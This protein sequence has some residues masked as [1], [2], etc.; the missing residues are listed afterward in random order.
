MPFHRSFLIIALAVLQ[1]QVTPA[2]ASYRLT[3]WPAAA[4]QPDFQ[5]IDM[6]GHRRSLSDYAGGVSIVFFGYT[7]CPDVC[8]TELLELSQILR[9]LGP[10]ASHVQVLFVTLDP[11]RDTILAQAAP[12]P[13]V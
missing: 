9:T 13:S 10:L 12:I 7:H 4:P 11:E 2:A 1:S 5:L 3:E 6:N 8:P